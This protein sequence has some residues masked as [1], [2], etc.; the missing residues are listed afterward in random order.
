MENNTQLI[1]NNPFY[2]KSGNSFK[3]HI[4]LLKM[5]ILIVLIKFIPEYLI[6]I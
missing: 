4:F 2:N 1:M 3:T 5:M 6:Y